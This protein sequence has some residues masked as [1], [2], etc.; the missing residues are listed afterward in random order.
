[1][2]PG[3]RRALLGGLSILLPAAG[4][5]YLGAVS[6]QEDRGV[7]AARL[8]E[9]FRAAKGVAGEVEAEIEETVAAVSGSF[10][11]GGQPSPAQL[12]ILTEAHSLAARPFRIG[13]DGRLRYPVVAPLG[14][15]VDGTFRSRDTRTCPSRGFD[16]CVREIRAA[17]RREAQ[18]VEARRSEFGTCKGTPPV[19]ESSDRRLTEARRTYTA[20]ARYDDSGPAAL[21]GL[22]RLA[23]RAGKRAQAAQ[24]YT[25]L[26]ERFAH[27]I[28]GEGVPYAL[29]ADLGRAEMAADSTALLGLFRRLVSRE[30]SG[31][32]AIL[33]RVAAHTRVLLKGSELTP[34][35]QLDLA[36]LD[37]RLLAARVEADFAAAISGDVAEIARTAEEQLHGRPARFGANT[38]I[39]RRLAD[40][41]VVGIVVDRDALELVAAATRLGISGLAEGARVAV[42]TLGQA[43]H[44][45]RER[46]LA[47]AGFG[48]ILPH[49]TLAL[50]NDR[51]QPDPLDEIVRSRGRRHLGIT[52]GLM[53]LLMVGLIATIRGAARERELARQKSE[54]VATVSH[55]LKTPLT[56]IRMFAEMLQQRVAGG[57]HQREQHY[58]EIIVKESER[59]GLLIANLLDYAQIE[60]GTRRY[61]QRRVVAAALVRDAVTTFGRLRKDE[62]PAIAVAVGADVDEAAIMVDGEVVVQALI[63]LLGN[64][65][66]YGG[67]DRAIEVEVERRAGDVVIAVRDRGPGIPAAEQE[68]I[69][70]QFYRAPGAYSSSVEGTGLGLALVK[71]HVEAQG[72]SVELDST[73]GVGS[74]FSLVFARIE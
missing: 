55:E 71:R 33:A 10:A 67:G 60:R 31:P 48:P 61:S 57:D 17:R 63:N 45:A 52:G 58:H 18:L 51:A 42:R 44:G 40:G 50:V 32:A 70:R 4:I 24:H 3:S 66:K 2:R 19:C 36:D 74:T 1:M 5:V 15:T 14:L 28:D 64:A 12:A 62:E 34:E 49:L 23:R 38:F 21:L 53:L 59:L 30:Y 8:D 72:G 68:R 7:V 65:V 56:S 37:E 22:A 11:A 39:Y 6:Y 47:S 9:L 54:F 35:M 69:F 16:A 29:V 20:L 13:R 26:G 25:F 27:R 46:G 41:S 43:R 73:V